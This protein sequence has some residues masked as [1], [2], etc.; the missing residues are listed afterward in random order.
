MRRGLFRAL[1][2][3]GAALA[4][5]AA[6]AVALLAPTSAEA[7]TV[8]LTI[9]AAFDTTASQVPQD[10]DGAARSTLA[11]CP[12]RCEG[13]SRGERQAW[14]DFAVRG[15]PA[16]AV[17]TAAH[18]E[19]SAWTAATPAV[20]VHRLSAAASTYRSWDTRP[21]TKGPLASRSGVAKG[22]NTWDVTGTVTGNT[23]VSFA[24]VQTSGTTRAY[25]ASAENANATMRPRLVV[26]YRTDGTQPTPTTPSTSTPST[27]AP[28]T[29]KPSTTAPSTTAPSTTKPTTTAPTTT[30]PT[31]STPSTSAPST[32]EP[33]TSAPTTTT[34][35]TSAPSTTTP[36]P[37]GWKLAWAD[38][39]DGT[40]VDATKWNTRNNTHVDYDKA[41]IKG[42]NA[43]VSGGV[44]TLRAQ[45]ERTTCGSVTR[46]YSSAYVDSIGKARFTR[47]RFEV[48]AQ[49]PT[50]PTNSLGIW[51]A[52][53]L[54]PDDGKNGEIDIVELPGGSAWYDKATAAI[55]NSYDPVVK[56][57]ARFRL[58]KG[59]P[60]DGFHVYATE[61][62][63]KELRWYFDGALVYRRDA[64]TTS[65]FDSAFSKPYNWRLN[66]QVGGW[67]GD[68][69]TTTSFPADFLVDYVRVYQ[70]QA[71]PQ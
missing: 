33:S 23:R 31:T 10:G 52:A 17:V 30:A 15:L 54:R 27:T 24:L 1:T 41:C 63:E 12:A 49:S 36:A 51:P 13:N 39:F 57:D 6:G 55:F 11:T 62:D 5:V 28:S 66:I 59:I 68:P 32:T 3:G 70:Q 48:R 46:D 69:D 22:V 50:G 42:S 65:W 2:G 53:W 34:P 58:P 45:R 64:T 29:T 16:G 60:A 35:T 25:W 19:V 67:L 7:S 47:G 40:A 38:E 44:L 43:F 26:E 56:Q 37:D 8:R 9:Q 20:A 71:A 61:W 4:V 14:L 18:L 21:A